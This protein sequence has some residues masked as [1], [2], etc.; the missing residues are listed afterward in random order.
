MAPAVRTRPPIHLA[1][2]AKILPAIGIKVDTTSSAKNNTTNTLSSSSLPPPPPPQHSKLNANVKIVPDNTHVRSTIVATEIHDDKKAKDFT[3]K[4]KKYKK[5][6]FFRIFKCVRLRKLD[7]VI[8]DIN[9]NK[10]VYLDLFYYDL[11]EQNITKVIDALVQN[12]KS[13]NSILQDID[14]DW[15]SLNSKT[16]KKLRN[17]R[18][19][20]VVSSYEKSKMYVIK[21]KY[22]N[23]VAKYKNK[24]THG[25]P[26]I[27]ACQEGSIND[28]QQL[29]VS[30]EILQNASNSNYTLKQMI[31]QVGKDSRS[32][33]KTA[34][35]VAAEYNHSDIVKYL[36]T[37]GADVSIQ[38]AKGFTAL[39]F[40]SLWN[41][42]EEMNINAIEL[43]LQKMS[44]DS[45]NGKADDGST[46]LDQAYKMNEIYFSPEN[47]IIAMIRKYG[48]K[49]NSHDENGEFVGKGNGDL[50]TNECDTCVKMTG[51]SRKYS[52][53][54]TD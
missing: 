32:Y 45:I 9:G 51:R 5:S 12:F 18:I 54:E 30:H 49:A 6:I 42:H 38:D 10:L 41:E 17:T 15:E 20:A 39:H 2:N 8:S 43:M 52:I 44:S 24:H 34:L 23:L 37:L 35:H 25:L 19:P 16:I 48:G 50:N 1:P 21:T 22:D 11:T 36:I 46:A 4:Q 29:V 13:G 31:N 26:F 3:M 28:V 47:K 14:I 40:A 53:D 27:L 33:F 7:K